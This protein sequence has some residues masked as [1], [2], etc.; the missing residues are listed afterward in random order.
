MLALAS[1]SVATPWSFEEV[2]D[3]FE[4][5]TKSYAYSDEVTSL[6]DLLYPYDG[7][8]VRMVMTCSTESP[9]VHTFFRFSINPTFVGGKPDYTRGVLDSN[10]GLKVK[11]DDGKLL[12]LRAG[13]NAVSKDAVVYSSIVWP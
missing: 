12:T 9:F 1:F 6:D 5:T 2:V 7:L 4:G 11:F 8:K 10:Y 13:K 3:Q